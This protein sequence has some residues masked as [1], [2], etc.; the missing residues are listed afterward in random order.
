MADLLSD[1][2]QL[3]TARQLWRRGERDAALAAFDQAL[4]A[5]P[6]NVRAMVEAASAFGQ[7]FQVE[8]A[9]AL[10]AHAERLAGHDPRVLAAVAESYRVV[11]RPARALDCWLRLQAS[12][13]LAPQQWAVLAVLY[14]QMGDFAAATAA[15]EACVAAAPRQ[16]EPRLI[17]ARLA[18]RRGDLVRAETLLGALASP[19]APPLLATRAWS[20]LGL[21]RDQQGDYAG[22]AEAAERAKEIQR[23][24]PQTARLVAQSQ[25]LN[26][27]FERLYAGLDR[28]HIDAWRGAKL[29]PV[30]DCGGFAHLLGFPR[31]GTTLLEQVL[32][33][34]PGMVDAPERPVFT[35][36]IFPRMCRT[37]S[38]PPL[39]LAS[40][41][42]MPES[43]LV[44]LRERYAVAHQSIQGE[45]LAGRSLLDKNPNH[46]AHMASLLRL[47]PESR[48]VVA[49]RDPRD[50]VVSAY[51]RFFSLT[52]FSAG[53]LTWRSTC[54]AY[55]REMGF[56]LQVR[57]LMEGNWL[58][59][60]YEDVV[61]DLPGQAQR[62]VEFL[63]L[64]WAA[65]VLEYRRQTERK[66]VNS[67]SQA[68]VRQPVYRHAVGRWQR[69]A[70][71]LA[72]HLAALRPYLE[73]FGYQ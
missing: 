34:H 37:S 15:I 26:A 47:L 69:Y 71:Q 62:T 6:G 65:E 27:A 3:E 50:V 39:S 30:P 63:G 4:V 22:A 57:R 40:F 54:E 36:D 60:R 1:F 7:A 5:Q 29:P 67:P 52:E 73:A 64:S 48:F 14:E 12:A 20:E 19:Q 56:W 66:L 2:P 43:D 11:Y 61:A 55:A 72:P 13:G 10:L 53:F 59:V 68:E 24:Q 58:E 18:R 16:A 28:A 21:V 33:A 32:A 38:G 70:A 25:R 17:E 8:R 31:T 23:T 44:R 35:Q 51:L 41:D 42:G 46:T 9:E 45:P 49:L